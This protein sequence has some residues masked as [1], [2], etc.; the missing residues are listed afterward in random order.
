[1]NTPPNVFIWSLFILILAGCGELRSPIRRAPA[2]L[3]DPNLTV[4][5]GYSTKASQE[6]GNVGRSGKLELR[7]FDSAGKSLLCS[8]SAGVL[9]NL[10][11]RGRV[12]LP[13]SCRLTAGSN[14]IIRIATP[15]SHYGR[16][17]VA[18]AAP[19]TEEFDGGPSAFAPDKKPSLGIQISVTSQGRILLLVKN[20]RQ[21]VVALMNDESGYS[22]PGEEGSA[23]E[24]V[25]VGTPEGGGESGGSVGQPPGNPVPPQPPVY[26][27]PPP[28]PVEA[29][30]E[31]PKPICPE[32]QHFPADEQGNPVPNED[33]SITCCVSPLIV[34]MRKNPALP[35]TGVPMTSMEN[36]VSFD[37]L[38]GKSVQPG[39]LKISWL[40]NPEFMWLVKPNERGEVNGINEMFGSNTMDPDGTFAANGYHALSKYD[41]ESDGIIDAKDAVFAKLRLWKDANL[42]G[43]AQATELLP[44]SRLGV[45]SL[46]INYDRKFRR[47]DKF[48]NQTTMKSAVHLRGGRRAPMYDVWFKTGTAGTRLTKRDPIPSSW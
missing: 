3:T 45:V 34:D 14:Y 8:S 19:G 16:S 38:G 32:G 36:G 33:G 17:L 42:D 15:D 35:V 47:Q 30:P 2:T 40:R 37:L 31:D 48:G 26:P 27:V 12:V 21:R 11:V 28:M 6:Y 44:L 29:P 5:H 24:R 43:R 13:P 18:L 1:M 41:S 4:A 39:K 46:E 20:R 9:E 23:P 10:V 22:A 25:I 7:L